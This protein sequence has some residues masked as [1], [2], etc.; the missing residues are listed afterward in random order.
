MKKKYLLILLL[1]CLTNI[2]ASSGTYIENSTY[3]VE[4]DT[5]GYL[6]FYAREGP[7]YY[8]DIDITSGGAVDIFLMDSSGFSD[9]TSEYEEYFSYY[10]IGS[11]LNTNG[12]SY[13]FYVDSSITFYIVIENADITNGGAYPTGDINVRITIDEVG[14]G[15][16]STSEDDSDSEVNPFVII[17]FLG[18][19]AV[20]GIVVYKDSQKRKAR[21]Q[22]YQQQYGMTNQEFGSVYAENQQNK[23]QSQGSNYRPSG[24]QPG[25]NS[26]YSGSSQN[27]G[28]SNYSPQTSGT[29]I[30]A[31]PSSKP[32]NSDVPAPRFCHKCGSKI[33]QTDKFCNGCGTQL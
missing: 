3:S 5:Y 10:V 24:S 17:V 13:E 8:V 26:P 33:I 6:T 7:D 29:S 18:I 28:S 15:G 12:F 22:L 14:S 27:A 21:K 4:R 23:Y 19:V 9:Y 2:Q 1:I 31:A 32:I 20:I 16:T 25:Y 11:R 30:G